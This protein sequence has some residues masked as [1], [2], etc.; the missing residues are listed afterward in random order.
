MKRRD[1]FRR[2]LPAT[3]LPS[4]LNGFS[5]R[6][7]AGSPLMQAL[8]SATLNDHALVLIQ[9]N[10]GNDGLNTVIPLDQYSN[11]ATARSNILVPD[12]LVLPLTGYANTGLHPSMSGIQQLFNN[13]KLN[14]I[15]AVGY[16]SPNF[17]H[18]RATDIWLSGSDSDQVL[19]SGWGGYI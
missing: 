19:S 16:P 2:T 9:L 15:Q 4:L 13:G 14:I 5:F 11:L 18:F 7:F 17:S 1:F 12:M 6:A 3:L 8:T 10:G